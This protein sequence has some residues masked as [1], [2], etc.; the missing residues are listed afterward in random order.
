[1]M[2][3]V[4]HRLNDRPFVLVAALVAKNTRQKVEHEGL[5]RGELETQ[6]PHRID[7]D[8]FKFVRDLGHESADLFHQT[9]H[10]GFGSGLE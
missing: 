10:T 1:M 5:L 6:G 7:H 3:N 9:I 8:N 2:D 4:K